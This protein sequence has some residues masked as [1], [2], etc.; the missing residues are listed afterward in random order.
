M[1]AVPGRSLRQLLDERDEPLA[2]ETALAVLKGSLL[3][4]AAAHSAG[5]VHR[6]YK[7]ANVLV[8]DDGRSK[9]IDFG[10]AVLS[11]QGGTSGT[12]A[13]MAPEQW[14]GEP[15]TSAT[16]LYAATCVF[17]ECITGERV[18][19]ATTID[20]LRIKHIE[21]QFLLERVLR[22][23]IPW[24]REGWPRIHRNGSG[25]RSSSSKNSKTS[26]SGR[27]APT[28]NDEGSSRWVPWPHSSVR[29][30]H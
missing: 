13:Y 23:F 8:Q 22:R 26:P 5:V 14:H 12:P 17:V 3:G 24:S 9:L 7:P 1:E 16:D 10:I 4:L 15:A 21:G 18:F 2:P 6:D 11:G 19:R 27:M 20:E 28:G 29:P 30:S 25:T